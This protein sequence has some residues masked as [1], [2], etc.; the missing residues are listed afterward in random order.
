[1]AKIDSAM[2]LEL[3]HHSFHGL[4]RIFRLLLL[5]QP[6]QPILSLPGISL[7]ANAFAS[8]LVNTYTICDDK[9]TANVRHI[10]LELK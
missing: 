6:S 5:V 9:I 2:R 1:M 3:N 10:D 8:S 7:A 4:G